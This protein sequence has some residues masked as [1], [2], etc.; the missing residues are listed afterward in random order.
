MAKQSRVG[1]GWP[2][3]RSARKSDATKATEQ[4]AKKKCN[5]MRVAYIKNKATNKRKRR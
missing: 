5:F 2:V 4:T 1:Q 3:F